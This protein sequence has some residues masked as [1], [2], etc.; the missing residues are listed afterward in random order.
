ML[1]ANRLT[2]ASADPGEDSASEYQLQELA[3]R[4]GLTNAIYNHQKTIGSIKMCEGRLPTIDVN[5]GTTQRV[6]STDG[7]RRDDGY[8]ILH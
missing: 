5:A 7:G 2:P 1:N 4:P 8:V 6:T 3:L